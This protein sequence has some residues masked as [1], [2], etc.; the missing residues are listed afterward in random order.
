MKLTLYYNF[1]DEI[2]RD[3]NDAFEVTMYNFPYEVESD[4][5]SLIDTITW[6]ELY[7]GCRNKAFELAAK[8]WMNEYADFAFNVK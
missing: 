4:N 7:N 8:K 5:D 1:V 6:R 3:G 2:Y